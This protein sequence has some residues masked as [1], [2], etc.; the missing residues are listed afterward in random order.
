MSPKKSVPSWL[1]NAGNSLPCCPV[2]GRMTWRNKF[3]PHI[4][5]CIMVDKEGGVTVY[6]CLRRISVEWVV[7]VHFQNTQDP[8]T[9]ST[10][11][12]SNSLNRQ[13]TFLRG[14]R[15]TVCNHRDRRKSSLTFIVTPKGI[16]LPV[17]LDHSL[18]FSFLSSQ[19]KFDSSLCG[20][21][22][23]HLNPPTLS[24]AMPLS[25]VLGK[26]GGTLVSVVK[27]AARDST[28]N[29]WFKVSSEQLSQLINLLMAVHV[30]RRERDSGERKALFTCFAISS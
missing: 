13:I 19:S 2:A 20:A 25:P 30:W 7:L 10:C 27:L 9:Q 17:I 5:L 16:I 29:E 24:T 8:H 14:Q 18:T 1:W 15:I 23:Q 26:Q 4:D 12:Y 22:P 21:T 11:S 6:M 28:L 3:S